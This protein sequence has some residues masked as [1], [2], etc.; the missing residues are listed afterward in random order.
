MVSRLFTHY[1]LSITGGFISL[2]LL[3][4]VANIGHARTILER[5]SHTSHGGWFDLVV[6]RSMT[7][8]FW[9]RR[10]S[11][12]RTCR[13]SQ[14]EDLGPLYVDFETC[15]TQ[16]VVGLHFTPH[17]AE[18]DEVEHP[19]FYCTVGVTRKIDRRLIPPR[20]IIERHDVESSLVWIL[21]TE[22]R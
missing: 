1:I 8:I 9:I 10:I 13:I 12:N 22:M 21:G 3:K 6:W 5:R 20:T 7:V 4:T 11:R 2:S 17:D 19:T 14:E 18:L 15:Q 16:P